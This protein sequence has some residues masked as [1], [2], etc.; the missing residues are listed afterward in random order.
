MQN[1]WNNV[2]E[3]RQQLDITQRSIEQAEENLRLNRDYYRAGTIKMSDLLEA[4]L[5]CQQAHDSYTDAFADY[6]NKVLEYRQ[7]VGA[8]E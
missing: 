7:A 4:Q 1:A 6:Q 8:N 2:I 3:A 5:L